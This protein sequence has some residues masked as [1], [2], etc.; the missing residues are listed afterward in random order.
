MRF[1]MPDLLVRDI[2]P[3]VFDRMRK[4]ADAEGKSLAQTAREAFAEKFK[5]D[6]TKEEIWRAIDRLRESVGSVSGDSTEII[7]KARARGWRGR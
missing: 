6:Q 5:P 7:R 1:A 3:D 4:A 2:D